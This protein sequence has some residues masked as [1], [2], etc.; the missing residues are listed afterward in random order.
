[1]DGPLTRPII[2]ATIPAASKTI[3]NTIFRNI[4][5]PTIVAF[6]TVVTSP[7]W[8]V[9][10]VCHWTSTLTLWR[11][12]SRPSVKLD[13][14]YHDYD[15]LAKVLSRQPSLPLFQT[16]AQF[17]TQEGYCAPTTERMILKSIP[18]FNSNSLS[19]MKIGP[20]QPDKV[21]ATIDTLAKAGGI[22]TRSHVI[23]GSDGYTPFL[24]ALRKVNNPRYRVSANFLRSPLFGIDKTPQLVAS[25]FLSGHFSPIVGFDEAE[26]VV[27]VFDVNAEYGLFLVDVERFYEAVD[28]WDVF[29]GKSRGLVVTEVLEKEL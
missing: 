9:Q 8:L 27:A 4:V 24:S 13:S 29:E 11:K 1:M 12:A 17:Q 26:G 18:G 20:S 19:P 6:V 15:R 22:T 5:F 10:V 21:A 3:R 16:S 14:R 2:D 25:L 7:I 28:T 23:Y